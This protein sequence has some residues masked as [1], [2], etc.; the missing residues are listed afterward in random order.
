MRPEV[1]LELDLQAALGRVDGDRELLKEIAELFLE[2]CPGSLEAVR[3]AVASRDPAA[4]QR[5]AHSLKGAVSNFGERAAHKAALRLE[6]MGRSGELAGSAEALRE[7]E[8]ALERL[9][10]ELREFITG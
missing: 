2:E 10:A 3:A 6:Q 7:L 1:V 4:L 5:A 8:E 9:C